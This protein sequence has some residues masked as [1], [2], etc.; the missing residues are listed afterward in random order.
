MVDVR[1]GGERVHQRIAIKQRTLPENR[2]VGPRPPAYD[3]VPVLVRIASA[4]PAHVE[5]EHCSGL[6]RR[7]P[8]MT[9]PA[10][11]SLFGREYAPI[12]R[13]NPGRANRVMEE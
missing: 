12:R 11:A 13:V 10:R 3:E 9:A 2:Q 4:F 5:V 7:L 8:E 6:A 1:Q